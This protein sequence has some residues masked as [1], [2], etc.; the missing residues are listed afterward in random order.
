MME[1]TSRMK[2]NRYF[3]III[4]VKTFSFKTEEPPFR[5]LSTLKFK[6]VVSHYGF[7]AVLSFHGSDNFD[8][9]VTIICLVISLFCLARV[10]FRYTGI[11]VHS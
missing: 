6:I 7:S 3:S 2:Q 8:F 5:M 10:L 9:P 11:K 4:G 1:D